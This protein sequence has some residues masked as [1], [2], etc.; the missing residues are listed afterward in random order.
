MNDYFKIDES[1]NRVTLY[2]QNSTDILVKS[3]HLL[4]ITCSLL[5]LLLN[6]SLLSVFTSDALMAE[7]TERPRHRYRIT[8]VSS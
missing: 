7:L 8:N 1:A 3:S 6:V 2:S 4:K 5:I